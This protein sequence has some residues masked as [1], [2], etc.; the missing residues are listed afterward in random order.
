[1]AMATTA[2]QKSE[3]ATAFALSQR[4]NVRWSFVDKFL[5]WSISRFRHHDISPRPPP[6]VIQGDRA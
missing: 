1:M 6:P 3:P 4:S 5:Y 2:A